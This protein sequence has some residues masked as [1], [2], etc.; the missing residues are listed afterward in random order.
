LSTTTPPPAFR[1]SSALLCLFVYYAAYLAVI[2]L[3]AAFSEGE[4]VGVL[5][6]GAAAVVAP[7][8]AVY[9]GLIRYAPDEP[10]APALG[11]SR[12][13]G[14][15]LVALAVV[16]GAA[17]A[18]LAAELRVRLLEWIPPDALPADLAEEWTAEL[19]QTGMTIALG[20]AGQLLIPFA[21]EVLFRGLLQRRLARAVG[22][23]RAVLL[24][25]LLYT[26][27]GIDPRVMPIM[28]VIAL[29]FGLLALWA[30]TT[31]APVAG[32]VGFAVAPLVLA[33]LGATLPDE[34]AAV[35]SHVAPAV[36]LVSVGIALVGLLVA[37]RLRRRD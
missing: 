8:V 10:T 5:F 35:P 24:V 28:A 13:S 18:P 22:S 36:L 27:A 11:L 16:V 31:W 23:G 15:S 30:G 14:W 4:H 33:R 32:H 9:V 37:W 29:P 12:P 7:L 19:S 21:E 2:M 17:L 1:P 25:A 6:V 26:V 3:G 20:I 34:E